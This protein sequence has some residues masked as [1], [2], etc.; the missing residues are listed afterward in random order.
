[1]QNVIA[2]IGIKVCC[3]PRDV[4][5][6]KTPSASW[7]HCLLCAISFLHSVG[8]L[9]ENTAI[10]LSRTSLFCADALAGADTTGAAS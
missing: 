8:D 6:D 4:H 3:M 7:G 1:M 2:A 5:L 10:S 9:A